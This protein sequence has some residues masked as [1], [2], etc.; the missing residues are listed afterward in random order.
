MTNSNTVLITVDALRADHLGQYGYERDTMPVLDRLSDEGTLF[1]RTYANGSHTRPS[2]PSIHSSRYLG[3]ADVERK[4]TIASVLNDAGLRTACIGTQTGFHDA[5]GE[6]LFD[7]YTNL[8]RDEFY[9][10][11][12]QSRSAVERFLE[13]VRTTAGRIRPVVERL[14]PMYDY[15]ETVYEDTVGHGF[16]YLGYTSAENVVDEAISWLDERSSEDFFLWIHFMEGHR[17]Y[18]VHDEAPAYL[19]HPVPED[20]IRRLMKTAGLS[21]ETLT[22]D[23]HERIVDMYDSNLSYCSRQLD[24]LFDELETRALWDDTN[25]LFSADH[26]EEFHEHGKYFHVNYPYDE[27]IHVPLITKTERGRGERVGE[28]REL[29]DLGPTIADLHGVDHERTSFEGKPLFEGEERTVIAIGRQMNFEGNAIAVRTDSWKYIT[30]DGTE[31][32]YDLDGDSREE[33]DVA[34]EHPT[35]V[36]RLKREV[37]DAVFEMPEA[38]YGDVVERV[39]EERLQALGYLDSR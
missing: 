39:P 10:Q 35:V 5:A 21:P 11:A 37:P 15:V 4:D 20:E 18:G 24:R 38:G 27:L 13:S 2:I 34:N 22:I 23:D 14:G 30:V 19:D 28:R 9:E 16:N 8:G 3:Y 26:G 7:E 1:E 29:L 33:F 17:P 32:L 25:L 12:D 36:E 31:Y 6:L